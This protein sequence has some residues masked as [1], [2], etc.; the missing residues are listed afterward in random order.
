M[1]DSPNFLALILVN[2][3]VVIGIAIALRYSKSPNLPASQV[4]P[5][6]D[7]GNHGNHGDRA[8]EILALKQECLNLR[9]QIE[10]QSDRL[11]DAHREK[12]FQEL[13]S[14]LTQYKSVRQMVETKPD[15]PAKNLIALFTP[16]DNLLQSWQYETIG[17]TWQQVAYDPQ[18]HQSDRPDIADGEM[19]YVRFVGYKSHAGDI[20][21][22]AKVSRTL[23]KAIT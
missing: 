14:L 13:Q 15:L 19:V 2:L 4:E 10:Q 6:Q 23:P 11:V 21:V 7:S 16:L 8:T 5:N 18:L 22:P 20:L 17:E 9:E 1:F 12:T 3:L